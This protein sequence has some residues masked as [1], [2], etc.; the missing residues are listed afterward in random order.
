ARAAQGV[1]EEVA[2]VLTDTEQR[3]FADGDAR[4]ML[5][6]RGEYDYG[7]NAQAAVD[8]TSGVILAAILTNV[9]ADGGHLPE[10][11][12]EVR[13]WRNIAGLATTAPTTV[14]ADAGYFSGDNVAEDGQGLDLLIAT[15]REDPS[16]TP[17]KDGVY[18][19]DRF[20]YDVAQDVWI[21][22]A[23]KALTLQITP[24]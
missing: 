21:C 8:E 2:P 14:S 9:A 15:G 1:P 12:A 17:R 24:P 23:S 5:M 6:K 10:L 20:G 18:A 3:S 19:A 4:M 7:Y 11:V 22:P 13:A 16:A